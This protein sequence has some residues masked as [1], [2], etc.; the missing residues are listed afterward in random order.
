MLVRENG[1]FME[2]LSNESMLTKE[3]F[4]SG[5]RVFVVCD[6]DRVMKEEFQRWMIKNSPPKQVKVMAGADH[7]VMLSQPN[8]VSILLQEIVN[9]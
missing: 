5:N 3:G 7:M 8:E 6:D 1:V 4:G 2:D 9:H